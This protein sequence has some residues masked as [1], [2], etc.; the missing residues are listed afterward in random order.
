MDETDSLIMNCCCQGPSSFERG[1]D[2]I[3][4]RWEM[5]DEKMGC[6]KCQGS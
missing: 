2:W 5:A 1:K 3:D 4:G 6:F